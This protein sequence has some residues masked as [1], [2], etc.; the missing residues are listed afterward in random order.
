M[1]ADLEAFNAWR[2]TRVFTTDLASIG[3]DHAAEGLEGPGPHPGY[4]YGDGGWI[5]QMPDGTYWTITGRSDMA[6]ADLDKVEVY[7]WQN[8][9]S[10]EFV[11]PRAAEG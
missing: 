6:C 1:I 2:A 5:A 7:L 4:G 11:A 9:S 8:H 10:M 3:F